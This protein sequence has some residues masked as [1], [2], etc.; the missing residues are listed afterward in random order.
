M[1][2]RAQAGRCGKRGAKP[3]NG[4]THRA[5]LWS[6]CSTQHDDLKAVIYDFAETRGGRHAKEFVGD[7]KGKLVCDDYA[8]YKALFENG[9]IEAGCMAHAR[10]KFHD[11]WAN[12]SSQIAGEALTLYGALYEVEREVATLDANERQ[13]RM[14]EFG[15]AVRD[16]EGDYWDEFRDWDA[17]VGVSDAR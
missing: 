8:G 13:R 3:G 16:A 11:L 1:R 4:K 14:E 12:H 15:R 2:V 17:A 10:R 9:V 6:W 5:Y 7:W